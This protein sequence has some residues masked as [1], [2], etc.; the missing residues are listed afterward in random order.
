MADSRFI[1][2]AVSRRLASEVR[3]Q[4]GL[5]MAESGERVSLSSVVLEALEI[6]LDLERGIPSP[7]LEKVKQRIQGVYCGGN[8]D[9]AS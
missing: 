5:R 3:Q 7:T 1:T 8:Q 6:W 9:G 4:C 2:V